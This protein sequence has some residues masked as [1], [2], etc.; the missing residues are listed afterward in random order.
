LP[1]LTQRPPSSERNGSLMLQPL[2]K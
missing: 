1:C 2:F